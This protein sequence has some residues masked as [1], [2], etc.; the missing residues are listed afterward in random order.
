MNRSKQAGMGNKTIIVLPVILA[1]RFPAAGGG[2]TA[3]CRMLQ[4][5]GGLNVKSIY[6]HPTLILLALGGLLFVSG[7]S[8][9]ATATLSPGADL[10]KVKTFYVVHQPRDTHSIH[11]RPCFGSDP[12]NGLIYQLKVGIK[13]VG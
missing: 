5:K 2:K 7:C 10:S 4:I 8:N 12:A 11:Y 1:S 6:A 13:G 3:I 9:H